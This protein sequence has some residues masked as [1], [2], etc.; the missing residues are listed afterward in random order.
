MNNERTLDLCFDCE[1]IG[2]PFLT[3]AL[4]DPLWRKYV[5]TITNTVVACSDFVERKEKRDDENS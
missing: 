4:I 1:R 2:D 3:C 5:F